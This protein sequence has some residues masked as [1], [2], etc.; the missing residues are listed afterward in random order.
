MANVNS[1]TTPQ[2][3]Y[4]Y[5]G[6]AFPLSSLTSDPRILDLAERLHEQGCRMSNAHL[7]GVK[8]VYRPIRIPSDLRHILG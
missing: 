3:S 5:Q 6:E 8:F 2:N 1:T 4:R 7:N